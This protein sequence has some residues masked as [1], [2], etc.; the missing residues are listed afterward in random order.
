ME[1]TLVN[2]TATLAM[3]GVIWVVQAVVYPQIAIT[4]AL[5]GDAPAM[6]REHGRRIVPVV[7]LPMLVE[8][9]TAAAL[10]VPEW[11]PAAMPGWAA[12]LGAAL[13]VALWVLTTFVQVPCHTA[14]S[15]RWDPAV[16]ARLVRTNWA[17]TWCWT[18]RAALMLWVAAGLL[19]A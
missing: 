16:A 19:P 18:A 6:V 12:W 1:L 10:L 14:L 11:R 4:G 3:T 15:D 8:L 2:L 9:A 17:R 5:V 13:V 7:T